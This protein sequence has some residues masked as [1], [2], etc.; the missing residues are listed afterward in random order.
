MNITTLAITAATM[1]LSASLALAGHGSWHGG[2]QG[3]GSM[4]T[5]NDGT[6]SRDEYLAP[7]EKWDADSSGSLSLE[8]WVT[9]HGGRK[10]KGYGHGKMAYPCMDR[11]D[12]DKDGKVSAEEFEAVY[13]GMA[14][15]HPMLDLDNDGV[16]GGDEWEEFRRMHTKTDCPRTSN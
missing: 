16:V 15:S 5:D 12:T 2:D 6:V 8:E 7:F 13:P 14:K 1:V 4:D 10:G 9:N 11:V 3:F